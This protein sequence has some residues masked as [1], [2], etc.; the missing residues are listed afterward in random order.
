MSIRSIYK[1]LFSKEMNSWDEHQVDFAS[2]EGL[3][4]NETSI[5][6]LDND[7]SDEDELTDLVG[8][9]IEELDD[10]NMTVH[11]RLRL[12][13][14]LTSEIRKDVGY[15]FLMMVSAFAKLRLGNVILS[16][17]M[18]GG[19]HRPL[20]VTEHA[21]ETNCRNPSV[22]EDKWMSAPEITG[23]VQLSSSV[24]G[25]IKEAE[26]IVNNSC[27]IPLKE[28]IENPIYATAFARLVGIR[29]I[30]SGVLTGLGNRRDKSFTRLH[31]EQ[32]LILRVIRNRPRKVQHDWTRPMW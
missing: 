17:R 32:H 19:L 22:D 4:Q 1:G 23:V 20:P 16:P 7:V 30:L 21:C 18:P 12:E 8:E 25:H 26:M 28:L 5:R 14:K 9:R 10:D 6:M 2:A 15:K 27:Q 3:Q 31:Q 29:I 13:S 24:Y 11:E